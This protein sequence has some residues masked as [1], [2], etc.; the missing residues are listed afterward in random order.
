[1]KKRQEI[2]QTKLINNPF[3]SKLCIEA[4]AVVESKMF[5]RDE[6]TGEDIP[7]ERLVEKAKST[8]IYQSAGCKDRVYNLSA[9][10]K[11]LYLYLLYNVEV[12]KDWIYLNR[13]WYMK[14]NTIKSIN[15]YKE[16]MKELCR[17]EFMTP[18]AEYK[19]VFWINPQL[20]FNGNRIRKYPKRVVVGESK[21]VKN[22]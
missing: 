1:M 13:E 4:T 11:S 2:D 6:K 16:A 7:V 18:T 17:Y 15:T 10:A 9:A 14:K 19:D 12:N 5:V 3:A 20:F 8:R 21:W 22:D